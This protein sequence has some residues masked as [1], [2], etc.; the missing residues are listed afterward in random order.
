MKY[1]NKLTPICTGAMALVL[2]FHLLGYEAFAGE[3]SNGWRS[4]YDLILL[5]INFGIIVL[6]F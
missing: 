4:T 2:S 5:W 3:K 1:V 6:I